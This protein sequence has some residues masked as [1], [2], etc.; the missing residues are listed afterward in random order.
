M[1]MVHYNTKLVG[2]N[3]TQASSFLQ[4]YS[5]KQGIKKFGE[6]GIEAVHKEM[7]QIHDRGVFEPIGIE[8]MTK[9]ERKRAMESLIFLTEKRDETVKARVCANGSTQRAYISREEA[10]SPTAASEEIIITGV[11]DAKQKRDVMT[12]D[13][14]NVFVQTEISLDGDKIIMK[15]RG[16][17]VDILLELWPGVYDD[18]II[19]EGKHKIIYVRM[20]NYTEC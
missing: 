13:I 17:L 20:L 2:M 7:K 6:Q 3:D 15:I 10:S 9:L 11:I 16:Q 4:T 19:N 5:L 18:Y 8:E 12:L 1:T 14:P